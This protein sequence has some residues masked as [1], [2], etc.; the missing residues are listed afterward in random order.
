MSRPA[1]P[2]PVAA[3][4]VAMLGERRPLRLSA[5]SPAHDL[6]AHD[7]PAHDLPAHDLPAHVRAG[8]GLVR[9]R[10]DLVV[11][12]DDVNALAFI[13]ERGTVTFLPLP[14]AADGR[15]SFSERDGNKALKMDLE[16]CVVLPDGR[17]V[18]FGSGST[19]RREQIVVLSDPEHA[20]IVDGA[21]FYESLRARAD[22]SGSELN[23]EGAV[24]HQRRLRLFQRGNGASRGERGAVNAVGDVDLDAFLRWLDARGPVPALCAVRPVELGSASGVAFGFTD[25]LALPDGRVLFLAGAED[26]PDTYRDGEVLGARLGF[27]EPDRVIS[28]D[29]LEPDGTPTRLK[30]EGL[31]LVAVGP[32]RIELVVVADMDDPDVPC[33]LVPLTVRPR[34]AA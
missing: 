1:A 29:V 24:V 21:P 27:L 8:S 6:P 11:I 19:P 31:E 34:G 20:T 13:D 25:A 22:F 33:V 4:W 28:T 7:L 32:D 26:S 15:R 14:A 16:A 23:L 2:P 18:A 12:Q 17:L 10:G 9:W 30:L 5:P 3:D